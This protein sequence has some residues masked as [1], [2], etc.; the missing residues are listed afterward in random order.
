MSLLFL[1]VSPCLGEAIDIAVQFVDD[2]WKIDQR[3]IHF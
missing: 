2:G 1:M 3:L